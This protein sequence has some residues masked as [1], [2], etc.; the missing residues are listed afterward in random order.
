MSSTVGSQPPRPSQRQGCG[1]LPTPRHLGH[2]T[3]GENDPGWR[4]RLDTVDRMDETLRRFLEALARLSA[5]D[6]RASAAAIGRCRGDEAG[7]DVLWWNATMAIDDTL[8]NEAQ[9]VKAAAAAQRA[10]DVVAE[11]ARTSGLHPPDPDVTC[12]IRR[13]ME[14]ARGIVAGEGAG[15]ATSWLLRCWNDHIDFALPPDPPK[16]LDLD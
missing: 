14:V 10:S 6:I 7:D 12:L 1:Q 2:V 11:S 9:M 4:P 3:P 16:S 8:R 15:D 5:T 13:A